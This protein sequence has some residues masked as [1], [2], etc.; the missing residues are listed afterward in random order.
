[1]A[2]APNSHHIHIHFARRHALQNVDEPHTVPFRMNHSLQRIDASGRGAA[3]VR[4]IRLHHP[5]SRVEIVVRPM[6]HWPV[7]GAAVQGIMPVRSWFVIVEIIPVEEIEELE[8]FQR[9]FWFESRVSWDKFLENKLT[10]TARTQSKYS[11]FTPFGGLPSFFVDT[12]LFSLLTFSL[13]L[14]WNRNLIIFSGSVVLSFVRKF[15]LIL[16]AS[17]FRCFVLF[18]HLLRSVFYCFVV[19]CCIVVL[20]LS[21]WNGEWRFNI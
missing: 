1:M 17:F 3:T 14:R 21:N 15:Q 5:N 13:S 8:H 18:V 16:F 4:S 7:P 10:T 11:F 19:F 12:L 9:N 2:A 20:I 6:G